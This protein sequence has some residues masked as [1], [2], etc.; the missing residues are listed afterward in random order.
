[1]Q[2]AEMLELGSHPSRRRRSPT[3][4]F[5]PLR[6]RGSST[7]K[8]FRISPGCTF[9]TRPGPKSQSVIERVRHFLDLHEPN[10]SA[11]SVI[12]W[13]VAVKRRFRTSG[14]S[15]VHT[16]RLEDRWTSRSL[17]ALWAN[18]P[19]KAT[20]NPTTYEGSS[21]GYHQGFG[22]S[23]IGPCRI[24]NDVARPAQREVRATQSNFRAFSARSFLVMKSTLITAPVNPR[25]RPDQ[26]RAVLNT[27][28]Y[29][30]DESET[31]VQTKNRTRAHTRRVPGT[32][33]GGG[34]R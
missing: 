1:M 8:A 4:P 15:T 26:S 6:R 14:P 2:T 10:H 16:A 34:V 20:K 33:Y 17:D 25:D 13:I 29:D 7:A 27:S 19:V 24:N 28:L 18:L 30:C 32:P 9:G 12:A 22:V 3:I 31:I 21:H 11:L 23:S 5:C